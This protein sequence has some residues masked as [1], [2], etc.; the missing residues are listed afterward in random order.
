MLKDITLGQY[1]PGNSPVHRLDPRTKL[2]L[3]IVYIV[4]L[5]SA[6]SWLSYGLNFVFLAGVIAISQIPLKSIFTGMKPLAMIL[7]FTGIFAAGYALVWLVIYFV[8]RAKAEKLNKLL[9]G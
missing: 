1:F 9:K 3:L 5:F 2:I 6:K 7:V 4:S 8:E